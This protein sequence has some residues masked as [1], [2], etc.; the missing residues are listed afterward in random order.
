LGQQYYH[1]HPSCV[2]FIARTTTF[3]DDDRVHE[4]AR[5]QLLDPVS[6]RVHALGMGR[7]A[8]SMP[9]DEGARV[10]SS[11]SGRRSEWDLDGVGY[12][13]PCQGEKS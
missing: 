8:E 4:Y 5:V 3:G 9:D 2:P 12:R 6:E 13:K 1:T 10:G 11:S 7:V